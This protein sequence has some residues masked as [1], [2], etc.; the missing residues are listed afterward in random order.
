MSQGP[1]KINKQMDSFGK[2]LRTIIIIILT[3]ICA[4]IF[5]QMINDIVH[6]WLWD[7][8]SRGVDESAA[9]IAAIFGAITYILVYGA[10]IF[11]IIKTFKKTNVPNGKVLN[12]KSK[13]P[14]AYNLGQFFASFKSRQHLEKKTTANVI[15]PTIK[16]RPVD[17]A[18]EAVEI[19][20]VQDP[21]D[22]Q[23]RSREVQ[24]KL[25]AKY[26]AGQLAIQYREDAKTG[27]G[28]I[29]ELPLKYQLMYLEK[30]TKNPKA[31]IE[32]ILNSLKKLHH[33]DDS[34]FENEAQNGP[35]RRLKKTNERAANE[36]KKIIDTLGETVDAETI[37]K[38]LGN[39][40]GSF[41]NLIKVNEANLKDAL[42]R[43]VLPDGHFRNT[44]GADFDEFIKIKNLTDLPE[45]QLW[46]L[47][48]L[49]I[50]EECGISTPKDI[51]KF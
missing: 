7:P 20:P 23:E 8:S 33:N 28:E 19:S 46:S 18:E 32:P 37:A 12:D 21:L 6:D 48:I 47:F 30:L 15:S 49:Y 17:L 10:G 27:W 50:Y 40:H 4:A 43:G 45:N 25:K 16:T 1:N 41:G 26:G 36:Y 34:P 9:F 14:R 51:F 29:R 13:M 2:W 3:L 11:Y 38:K 22:D 44:S 24:N 5:P 31:D 35:Y 39:K 42:S